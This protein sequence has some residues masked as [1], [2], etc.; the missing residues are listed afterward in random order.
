MRYRRSAIEIEAPEGFGYDKIRCN[1]AES[2]TRDRSLAELG[3]QLD[4]EKLILQYGD[5]Q[6]H[7]GLRA[8]LAAE[9]GCTSDQVLLTPGAAG[10]LFMV[11]TSLLGPADQVVVLRPNYANN[12]DTPRAIG[13][14]I[15]FLDLQFADGW[16]YSA[17][18]LAAL[19]TPK[20]K[21]ISI[22][23]PHNPTG[24]VLPPAELE[25]I[26][27][28]AAAHNC[29][30]LVDETY[31]DLSL[32]P[33]GPFASALGSHVISVGS[34]SKAY[35]LPGLRMGW[36]LTQDAA[37]YETLLAAKE[38]MVIALPVIEEELAYQVYRQRPV[39]QPAIRA[40]V[41]MRLA[42]VRAWMAEQNELVWVEP[43]GGV[44]CFPQ[45]K[46]QAPIDVELFHS[47]LRDE[48]GTWVGPGHWFEQSRR[49]FRVGF[50]WPELAELD[51]GLA[52]ISRA[53]AAA[54]S[55]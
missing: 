36:L 21:L 6:G 39:L 48:L 18:D 55:G 25:Q 10:A 40:D 17:D 53:L 34:F 38:Q 50:G 52:S 5:H 15:R 42:R 26:V 7:A 28:L 2:S 8:L 31:R 4:A 45:I 32:T 20:T 24:T 27:A 11:A 43:R 12:I 14:E 54:R 16:R 23:T 33:I 35:G 3:V 29:H 49:G 13:C 51:E 37:L 47:I 22:T 41:D 44:I 9:G 1:L 46:E 19:I 30:L